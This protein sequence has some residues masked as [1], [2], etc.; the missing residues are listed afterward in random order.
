MLTKFFFVGRDG[1]THNM[2]NDI[3]NNWK[4]AEAVR[5]KC[6]GIPTVDMKNVCEQLEVVFFKCRHLFVFLKASSML[7][8]SSTSELMPMVFAKLFSF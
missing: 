5:I 4:H 8:L 3:H 6:M 7:I 2:L 1:L